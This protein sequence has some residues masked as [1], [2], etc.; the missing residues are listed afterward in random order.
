MFDI[1][2]SELMVIALVALVVIGPKDLPQ[3][4]YAVGK[5]VRKARLVAR[6]F[7]GHLDDMM[8]EA[9]LDDL[10]KQALKARDLNI[11]AM[12]ENQ[13]DPKGDL[14]AAFDLPPEMT[15]AAGHPGSPPEDA[16]P[17]PPADP[18]AEAAAAAPTP[19]EAA[20][21]EA[22]KAAADSAVVPQPTTDTKTT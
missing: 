18:L 2:W 13:I 6:D 16:P 1:G 7:Q 20:P 22:P 3:A 17:L 12:V 9:E 21:A 10:R 14:K 4:I 15:G 5:W 19:A 11:K 8:R